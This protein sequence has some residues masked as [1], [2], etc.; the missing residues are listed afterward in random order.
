[1]LVVFLDKHVNNRLRRTLFLKVE[2]DSIQ[3]Y[4]KID[5]KLGIISSF[6]VPNRMKR[7][8]QQP[9]ANQN[10]SEFFA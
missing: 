10:M 6:Q 8:W 5:T 2:W 4:W 7:I 1:M 9:R 3:G